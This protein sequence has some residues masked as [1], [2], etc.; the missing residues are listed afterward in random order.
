MNF[1]SSLCKKKKLQQVLLVE[2]CQELIEVEAFK[3]SVI[4]TE[5]IQ[6]KII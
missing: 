4:S 3:Y 2:S 6:T 1:G 5:S